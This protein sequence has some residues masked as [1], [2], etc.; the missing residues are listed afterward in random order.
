MGERWEGDGDGVSE[1]CGAGLQLKE[2]RTSRTNDLTIQHVI[3][4]RAARSSP[5]NRAILREFSEKAAAAPHVVAPRRFLE[6]SRSECCP[7]CFGAA[8]PPSAALGPDMEGQGR[9]GGGDKLAAPGL[10]K[11]NALVAST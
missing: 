3:A 8:I 5:G 6:K 9:S 2:Q 1:W 7:K 11:V 10:A 4:R